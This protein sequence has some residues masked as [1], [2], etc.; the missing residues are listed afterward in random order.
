VNYNQVLRI[1]NQEY[2]VYLT[3]D[4][5]EIE[6]GLMYLTELPLNYGILLSYEKPD[7][8]GVWMK[9]VCIPLDVIWIGEDGIILDKKTLQINLDNPESTITYIDKKSKYTL[10]VNADSFEGKIGDIVT[11]KYEGVR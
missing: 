1:G 11:F 5:K 3:K 4:V 7:Y 2:K 9:N 6:K 8:Y 10:E